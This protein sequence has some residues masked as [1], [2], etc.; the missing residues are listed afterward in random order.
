MRPRCSSTSVIFLP[1]SSPN[2]CICLS[3]SQSPRTESRHGM[4]DSVTEAVK[5]RLRFLHRIQALIWGVSPIS[6]LLWVPTSKRSVSPC[7]FKKLVHILLCIPTNQYSHAK[8]PRSTALRL[9]HSCIQKSDEQFGWVHESSRKSC[10]YSSPRQLENRF[11]T[12]VSVENR[13]EDWT[14]CCP[15]F[16]SMK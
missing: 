12:L 2:V 11:L 16:H 10:A 4:C 3:I 13:G 15:S 1:I 7:N 9:V 5:E 14:L 6:F 8:V